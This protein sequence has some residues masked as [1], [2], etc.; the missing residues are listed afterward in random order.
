M[1]RFLCAMILLACAG[2]AAAGRVVMLVDKDTAAQIQDKLAQYEQD[3]EA[4]FPVDLVISADRDWNEATPYAVREFLN[5]LWTEGGL[6]GAIVAGHI[7]YRLYYTDLFGDQANVSSMY[8]EDLDAQFYDDDDDGV[9][10]RRVQGAHQGPDIWL[11]WMMPN[12]PAS[13]DAERLSYF[14]DKCH[15][16]YTCTGR[17]VKHQVLLYESM[18]NGWNYSN[19]ALP[20]L[21]PGGFRLADIWHYG[22]DGTPDYPL[23]TPLDDTS[24]EGTPI[25]LAG[26]EYKNLWNTESFEICEVDAHANYSWH[27]ISAAEAK[28]LQKGALMNFLVGCQVGAFNYDPAGSM[29][30]NYVFGQSNNLASMGSV[31]ICNWQHWHEIAYQKLCEGEFLGR[32]WHARYVMEE[33]DDPRHDE[34]LVGNPF[35]RLGT[36]TFPEPD[37]IDPGWNWISIPFVP[38]YDDDPGAIFGYGNVLNKLFEWDRVR[39]TFRPYPDDFQTVEVGAGYMLLSDKVQSPKYFGRPL[40]LDGELPLPARGWSLIGHPYEQSVPLADCLVR[41]EATGQL[42]T[43]GEDAGAADPWVN[44][45]LIYWDSAANTARILSLSGGDDDSLRA[46]HGYCMWT[47]ADGLTLIVPAE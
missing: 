24:V 25:D 39:K 13:R 6:E 30:C 2:A 11:A 23:R 47:N 37:W 35:I 29:V 32:A 43:P 8:Y 41:R 44:W 31:F 27:M 15:Q 12:A 26:T 14:L 40:V 9:L 19:R 45:N 22:R 20:A 34:V 10:D 16:Y 28:V 38:V 18:D 1:M 5:Y 33:I 7:P 4:R 36:Y 17:Y 3:V 21:Y 42:R 46:W